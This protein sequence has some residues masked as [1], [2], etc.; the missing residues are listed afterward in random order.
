MICDTLPRHRFAYLPTPLEEAPRLSKALGGPRLFIKR[1]DR[2]GLT[3]GGNKARIFEFV[4]GDALAK[5]ATALITA[6]GTQSNHLREVTAAAN[7][8]GLKSVI[9]VCGQRRDE[10][11]QG[12]L[13]LFH[14]LG[15]DIRYYPTFDPHSPEL[16]A[17]QHE[18]EAELKAQGHT[19]YIVHFDL[20]PGLLGSAA[21]A[22]AAEEMA[23]Q[24][25]EQGVVP[26]VLYV[27]SGSG[28]T[29][30]GFV[31]GFK[32][33]G[34]PTRVVGVSVIRPVEEVREAIAHHANRVAD[35]LG[36]KTRVEPSDYEVVDGRGAGYGQITPE[37][38]ETL[39]LVATQEG[40]LLDPVY[41]GK[42]M[43][44]LIEHIRAG[45]LTATQSA[46]LVHTGGTPAL[47]HYNRELL[48]E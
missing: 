14:L 20:R 2:S 12:N 19:P 21:H 8:L 18:I 11:P 5:G 27:P 26:D 3:F 23:G 37:V 31:L 16:W 9:I 38:T 1:D 45:R 25:K 17:L 40:L 32:H 47:F 39:R 43:A 44:V 34:L 29:T 24:F 10:P 48:A 4:F 41:N 46:V 35:D 28:V 30:S 22:N 6:A 42:A 36:L 13:F 33:L 15:A 7:K